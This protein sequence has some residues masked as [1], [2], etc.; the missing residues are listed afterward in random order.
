MTVSEHWNQ[1]E[2]ARC[3]LEQLSSLM[4]VYGTDFLDLS[5]EE[6]VQHAAFH[7]ED[8]SVLFSLA[9]DLVQRADEMLEQAV[10]G[11]YAQMREKTEK[12]EKVVQ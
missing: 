9:E 2:N 7:Y 8:M 12:K 3:R 5:K 1:V 6:F 4:S 11:A 10:N